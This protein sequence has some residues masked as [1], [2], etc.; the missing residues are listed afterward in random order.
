MSSQRLAAML[1][2]ACCCVP[3]MAQSAPAPD[4]VTVLTE[5]PRLLLRPARLRL[6]RRERERQTTRWQQL[7]TLLAGNAPMPEPGFAQ[8][9]YYQIAGNADAGRKAVAWALGPGKDLRQLA[10][11]FDWCQD[12]LSEAQSRTLAERLEQG[13]A[14]TAG[15]HSI[16]AVRSRVLAAVALFD[17]VPRTPGR[18]L[19]H[20][21]HQWWAGQIVPQ[22]AAGHDV[23]PR[24]DAY[25]LFELLH[26]IR[27]STDQDLREACPR[28]FEDFPIEHL[29][30]YYPAPFQ[31]SE[32]D[33]HI[34]IM[35]K[36]G[37]P[38]LRVAALSRAA[39]LEMVAFDTNAPQSQVLQ[40]WL[41]HD[42]FMLRGTFGAPYEF[43][44]AN[45]YQP[46]LSYYHVPLV[47]HNPDFGRL[48][49]R[50]SWDDSATWFGYFD[51]VAQLFQNGRG[52]VLNPRL[53][54]KPLSLTE[55]IILLGQNLGPFQLKLQE[56]EP[57]FLVGLQP[58]Q[59]Y[60]VE[61][62]DEEMYEAATDPGGILEL[63]LPPGKQVG[64]RLRVAPKTAA[65]KPSL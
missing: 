64:V 43:L 12:L 45:P 34:G 59:T 21:I 44:W 56:D 3:L 28:F 8:A 36:P 40:G 39:E 7:E 24:D 65:S 11:V 58:R 48:F 53:A 42:H 6:L 22:L 33:F 26:V 52:T 23:I 13:M 10:L 35:A 31:G 1:A 55:A 25:A 19:D 61:I 50:S 57:V 14:Q 27:D 54:Q 62:D 9:L 18:E 60:E 46:G 30:S 20:D 2:A 37:E 32:N 17:H 4:A 38:D 63:E 41:M 5:H 15:D 49:V 16:P 51:G 29:L 47:Y